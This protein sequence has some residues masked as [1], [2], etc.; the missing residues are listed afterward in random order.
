MTEVHDP[1]RLLMIVE[2]FP[3]VVLKVI[4]QTRE[5]YE[6]FANNWIHLITVNPHTKQQ[7]RLVNGRFVEYRPCDQTLE[8]ISDITTLLESGQENFPVY[9]I[10]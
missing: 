9:L 10:S 8:T 4:Q 2:H 5:L 7:S 6:W 3:E 1:I